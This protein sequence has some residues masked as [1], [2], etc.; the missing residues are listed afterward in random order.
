MK[1]GGRLLNHSRTGFHSP[2]ES[3]ATGTPATRMPKTSLRAV[4]QP[5]DFSVLASVV[6]GFPKRLL[7]HPQGAY[8]GNPTRRMRSWKRGSEGRGPWNRTPTY[9]LVQTIQSSLSSYDFSSH[10]IA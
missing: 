4:A 2:R 7:F 5:I 1:S 3:L 10:S 9:I 6:L 8:G